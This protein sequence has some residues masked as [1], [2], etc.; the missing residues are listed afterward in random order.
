MIVKCVLLHYLQWQPPGNKVKLLLWGLDYGWHIHVTEYSVAIKKKCT[1]TERPSSW[2]WK[3][4]CRWM[5]FC[6]RVCT[7]C[8]SRG[9]RGG[10][11]AHTHKHIEYMCK[12][13]DSHDAD[14]SSFWQVQLSKGKLGLSLSL[15]FL[16]I[17]TVII[18]ELKKILESL[19]LSSQ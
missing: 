6:L 7:C 8:D 12:I 16:P 5:G 11:R 17:W 2:K 15:T 14:E 19:C 3:K 18:G 9:G 1:D 13:K 4:R 10:S